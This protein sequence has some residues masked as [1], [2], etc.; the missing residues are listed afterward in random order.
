MI[1]YVPY[2]DIDRVKYDDCVSHSK[3]SR[4]YAF[5]WYLD[6]VT[7]RWDLIVEN[8]YETVMPLPR[9]TKYGISYVYTPSWVQQLGIFSSKKITEQTQ[10]AFLKIASKKFLWIDYH[11]NSGCDDSLSSIDIKKNYLLSLRGGTEK[12]Q[13]RYNK[14]RKRISRKSF[15][16]VHLVKNGSIEIFIE[17]FKNLDKTYLI[18]DESIDILKSLY[19]HNQDHVN[20]WNVFYKQQYVGGLIWLKDAHRI[21]Y[22]APIVTKKGKKEHIN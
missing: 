9:K 11:L 4:I 5:S 15:E 21:T 12:I 20:V 22:L 14:N 17:E 6:C 13:D 7:E 10:N 3:Y 18:S 1:N 16:N 2:R 19:L 8:D